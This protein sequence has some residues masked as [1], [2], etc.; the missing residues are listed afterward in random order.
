MADAD[1]TREDADG[2][3]GVAVLRLLSGAPSTPLPRHRHGLSREDVRSAQAARI[4]AASI[5]LFAGNGYSNTSVLQIAKLAGVSR[6]TFYELYDGKETVFLDTYD[7]AD[8]ILSG[9]WGTG[10]D[11]DA[12]RGDWLGRLTELA[13]GLLAVLTLTPAAT[14]TLF[15]EALGAGPRI[16]ERRNRSIDAFVAG[17]LPTLRGLRAAVEPGLAAVGERDARIVVAAGVELIVQHLIRAEP[18]SLPDLAPDLV[19]VVC[20]VVTPNHVPG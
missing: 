19:H 13:G 14:R 11:W 1:D 8:V 5:E 12:R 20:A 7:A 2:R 9:T 4:V 15:L 17:F 3:H 18:E 16:R 6:K 10:A